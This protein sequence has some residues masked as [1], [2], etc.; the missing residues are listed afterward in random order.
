MSLWNLVTFEASIQRVDY[1]LQSIETAWAAAHCDQEPW[2]T[3]FPRVTFGWLD[4]EPRSFIVTT[5]S[6][7]WKMQLAISFI[8][9]GQRMGF[10]GA[11][12][13]P[14]LIPLRFEIHSVEALP[15]TA[16]FSRSLGNIKI[17]WSWHRLAS[18]RPQTFVGLCSFPRE[19]SRCF[20]I[21]GLTKVPMFRHVSKIGQVPAVCVFAN[22]IKKL[23]P[24]TPA[25]VSGL[26]VAFVDA[27]CQTGLHIPAG[28]LWTAWTPGWLCLLWL[29]RQC[30]DP[31]PMF[32]AFTRST[33]MTVWRGSFVGTWKTTC[34]T[35]WYFYAFTGTSGTGSGG[36]Q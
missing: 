30:D 36:R 27:T 29:C 9:T 24:V 28:R 26:L 2:G 34:T 32:G 35:C 10:E 1:W 25:F 6:N 5:C 11:Q 8:C 33:C 20:W 3:P 4:L 12:L 21:L 19:V 23:T 17:W 15:G 22:V 13:I 7:V 18:M 31:W 14:L 16:V